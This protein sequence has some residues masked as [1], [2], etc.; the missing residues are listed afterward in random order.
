MPNS[1]KG[2]LTSSPAIRSRASGTAF[3]TTLNVFSN[4]CTFFSSARRPEYITTFSS[5]WMPKLARVAARVA[6]SVG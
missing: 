2:V 4:V 3:R 6:S 5:G 1:P